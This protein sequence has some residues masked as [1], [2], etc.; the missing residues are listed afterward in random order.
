MCCSI[1]PAILLTLL[2]TVTSLPAQ[3]KCVNMTS[4]AEIR[5]ISA[6]DRTR[7]LTEYKRQ[8]RALGPLQFTKAI[9]TAQ[10]CEIVERIDKALA[11]QRMPNWDVRW[12]LRLPRPGDSVI[13][14][15]N[16]FAK[17]RRRRAKQNFPRDAVPRGLNS[18]FRRLRVN[19]SLTSA[20][21][22][23]R[24]AQLLI[25][26]YQLGQ[27]K[28]SEDN[29]SPCSRR[30][31]MAF[32]EQRLQQC[33]S[34]IT[35]TSSCSGFSGID[36]CY[37]SKCVEGVCVPLHETPASFSLE[38]PKKKIA[39][40]AVPMTTSTS[41]TT[42]STPP[43]DI[44]ARLLDLVDEEQL[45]DGDNSTLYQS[46]STDVLDSDSPGVQLMINDQ[47]RTNFG[48]E[49]TE[50]AIQKLPQATYIS[51]TIA[52]TLS[53]TLAPPINFR[54]DNPHFNRELLTWVYSFDDFLPYPTVYFSVMV[55]AGKYKP[56]PRPQRSAAGVTVFSRGENL[57]NGYTHIVEALPLDSGHVI[58]IPDPAATDTLVEFSVIVRTNGQNCERLCLHRRRYVPCKRATVRLSKYPALTDHVH[59]YK[60]PRQ[61]IN[62]L[63]KGA[64]YF[65]RR[66]Q[67]AFIFTCPTR[68]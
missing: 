31:P 54:F 56:R 59:Y 9:A 66:T 65:R 4:R 6:V 67:D 2:P 14:S 53:S 42:T 50:T 45:S 13:F 43:T 16:F 34:R 26:L 19:D 18:H 63:W 40:R 68:L 52:T 47:N 24:A 29:C 37:A 10:L 36:P 38:P 51:A 61:V 21:R 11:P 62:R 3:V 60:T 1:L 17:M 64:G 48:E 22:A 32:C 8:R 5:T 58:R 30:S 33:I 28:E 39:E 46:N 7:L 20:I 27:W 35:V 55:I 41:T 49:A 25:M 23:S 44:V 15:E 12:D 57:P